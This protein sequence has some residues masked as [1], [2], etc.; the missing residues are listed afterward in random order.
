MMVACIYVAR[1][2][3]RYVYMH[4]YMHLFISMYMYNIDLDL[5][6]LHRL[7][8]LSEGD[9]KCQP[10]AQRDLATSEF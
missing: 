4:V 1:Y 6:V 2:V 7:V 3:R 5:G 8:S 10:A 9:L